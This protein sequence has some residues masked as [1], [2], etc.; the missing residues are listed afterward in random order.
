MFRWRVIASPVTTNQLTLTLWG[1]SARPM[2]PAGLLSWW[3]SQLPELVASLK[4]ARPEGRPTLLCLADQ[5]G[6]WS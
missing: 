4:Q 5:L 6:R 2:S 3:S 1:G